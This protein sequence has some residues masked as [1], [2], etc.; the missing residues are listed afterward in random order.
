MTKAVDHK[1]GIIQQAPACSALTSKAGAQQRLLHHDFFLR[2]NDVRL[3]WRRLRAVVC[4]VLQL[5]VRSDPSQKEQKPW[6]ACA[7]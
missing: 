5:A 4:H 7:L 1:V 3:S 6:G 2:T